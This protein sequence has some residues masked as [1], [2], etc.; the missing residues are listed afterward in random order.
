MSIDF[1]A[2]LHGLDFLAPLLD[3]Y[4][5]LVKLFSLYGTQFPQL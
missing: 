4:V 5:T 2:R 3:S 1:A